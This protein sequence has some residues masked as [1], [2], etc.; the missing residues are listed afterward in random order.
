MGR[1]PKSAY[2][3]APDFIDADLSSP[4]EH[5]SDGA[6]AVWDEFCESAVEAKCLAAVD[7]PLFELWCEA[8]HLARYANKMIAEE[9]CITYNSSGAPMKSPWV[10]MAESARKDV[11]ALCIE[12]GFSPKSRFKVEKKTGSE[13]SSSWGKP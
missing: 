13:K 12:L 8:V 5:M 1:R 4:P 2:A 3:S 7:L 11:R 6:K 10:Q 9:G